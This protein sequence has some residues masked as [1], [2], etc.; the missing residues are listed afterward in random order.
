MYQ[1]K[2]DYRLSIQ[3]IRGAG[4]FWGITTAGQ[5]LSQQPPIE[6]DIVPDLRDA[7]REGG[8]ALARLLG[9]QG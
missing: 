6:W 9:K 7:L 5:S 2:G 4:Y 3:P 8:Q 1:E